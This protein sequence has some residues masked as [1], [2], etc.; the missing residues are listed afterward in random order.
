[1]KNQVK[2]I[3]ARERVALARERAREETLDD[4]HEAVGEW[5]SLCEFAR[6]VSV[7]TTG[8]FG[9]NPEWLTRHLAHT[10]AGVPDR[11][12]TQDILKNTERVRAAYRSLRNRV[13]Q[14]VE[15][16]TEELGSY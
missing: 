9:R 12:R 8:W 3:T 16:L 11:V 2:G 6:R 15:D 13:R 14:E 1:M 4:F 5:E 10:W 7:S